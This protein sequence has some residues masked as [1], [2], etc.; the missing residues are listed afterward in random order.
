MSTDTTEKQIVAAC[1]LTGGVRVIFS[2]A[3][4]ASKSF[5]SVAGSHGSIW[6]KQTEARVR[7][8]NLKKC[9]VASG[10]RTGRCE[11]V[12]TGE[13]ANI[14]IRQ[15]VASAL[16]GQHVADGRPVYVLVS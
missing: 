5:I 6:A 8:R 14:L 12:V 2:I 11:A 15:R 16:S 9:M 10:T 3:L 7:I 1:L 13:S 4:A